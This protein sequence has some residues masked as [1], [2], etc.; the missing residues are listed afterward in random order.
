MFF[1]GEKF[2]LYYVLLTGA[3]VNCHKTNKQ[4]NYQKP[5][6]HDIESYLIYLKLKIKSLFNLQIKL[7]KERENKHK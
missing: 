5:R 3:P 2:A 1:Y 7:S 6:S 4:S